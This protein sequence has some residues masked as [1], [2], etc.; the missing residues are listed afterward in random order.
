MLNC[1]LLLQQV[2]Q[3]TKLDADG[4]CPFVGEYIADACLPVPE[5]AVV[6][7]QL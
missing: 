1:P 2:K 6:P 4:S 5:Q 7:L 3:V